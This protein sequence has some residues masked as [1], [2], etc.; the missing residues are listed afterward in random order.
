MNDQREASPA[1][2]PVRSAEAAG[3][4]D[5]TIIFFGHDSGEST[6]IKRANSFTASGWRVIGF[7]FKRIRGVEARPPSWEN[8][9]LGVTVDL[10][11]WKRVTKLLYAIV[12]VAMNGRRL[13]GSQVFYARNIDML[14]VAVVSRYITR[15][16]ALLVYE[17]L[18]IPRAMLGGSSV[19]RTMRWLERRLL[20]PCDLLVVS[21]PEYISRYFAPVQG[22]RGPWRLLENKISATQ[23]AGQ[24]I[25][26]VYPRAVPTPWVIGWFGVLRCVR[27][28][29]LLCSIARR[30]G[31][32]V[33][34]HVRGQASEEY[35][36]S[37]VIHKAAA[38]YPNFRFLGPYVS[39]Y[40]LPSIYSQIHF[41]WCIDYL[42]AGTNSDWLLPNRIYEGGL[43]GAVAL[44]RENTATGNMV[45]QNQLGY[46]FDEPLEQ[47]IA[48]FIDSMSVNEYLKARSVIEAKDISMFVDQSDTARLLEEFG[49]L[50]GQKN[51]DTGRATK[52]GTSR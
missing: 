1:P 42:D 24:R 9:E 44:A 43:F 35:L 33:V 26:R 34:I 15:S 40:D 17:A 52:R 32:K 19:N 18:D 25:Q 2:L 8:V 49:R 37:R 10:H 46:A 4:S 21:S 11:Y 22:Y 20:E 13:R 6:I 50:V 5:K 28:V 14:F 27:S 29:E 38:L 41:S 23:M 3:R 30:L 7:M 48:D 47:S 39:P 16:K 51:I 36:P 31:E 45:R 12:M